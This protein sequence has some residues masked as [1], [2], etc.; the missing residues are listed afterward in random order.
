MER[1]TPLADTGVVHQ[2]VQRTE[3]F[4][5]FRRNALRHLRIGEVT[6]Y[7]V[8]TASSLCHFREY[9]FSRRGIT[10]GDDCVRAGITQRK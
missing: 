7:Y 4:N 2:D 8:A 6:Q 9:Y 5:R 1:F 3:V 10:S